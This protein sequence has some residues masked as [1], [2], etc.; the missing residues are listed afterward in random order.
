MNAE[1]ITRILGG[2]WRGGAGSAAC[3]VCQ[4]ERRRDQTALS[5]RD[6]DKGVLLF[7][8]KA[9][10]NFADIAEAVSLP[11]EATLPDPIAMAEAR[12]KRAEYDAARLAKARAVWDRA[13]PIGGTNGERYIRS[14][15]I[16]CDL[17]ATLRYEPDLMHTTSGR[18]V[19]AVIGDI[20]STGGVH[21]T[22]LEKSG[23]VG[24]KSGRRKEMCGPCSGGAV[25]LSDGAGPLVVCE[26]IET[27]LS[28]LQSLS[29]RSPRVWAALSTSGIRGLILPAEAGEL[30]VAPDGDAPGR[31]AA[32]ALAE[33]ASASG[34]NVRVMDPGDGLDWNDHAKAEAA[35]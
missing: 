12:R 22:F 13:K 8:H 5:L 24:I 2:R 32:A 1:T 10:C 34:W 11:R 16:R 14:R 7:C 6:G 17:P 19:A 3:P 20:Q 35:A 21:V 23:G 26:G 31:E 18:W 33:R 25:R 27:G 15:G 29:D 9:G 28:L 4:P 30:I